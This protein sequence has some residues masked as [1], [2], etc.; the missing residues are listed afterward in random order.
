LEP[1]A[2]SSPPG[3][4]LVEPTVASEPASLKAAPIDSAA[5]GSSALAEV[6][7]LAAAAL[8]A[9]SRRAAPAVG[10]GHVALG[11]A[12]PALLGLLVIVI[13]SAR[14]LRVLAGTVAATSLSL[15]VAALF[16]HALVRR[17]GRGQGAPHPIS[18]RA[19]MLLAG[20]G[21]LSVAI[22]VVL[23]WGLSTVTRGGGEVETAMSLPP[24]PKLTIPD[25]PPEKRADYKLRREGHVLVSGG[26]LV[27]PPS[28]RSDD[29]AFDLLV[30]FH[31]NSQIVQES[32]GAAKIN[33]LVYIVNAGNGFGPYAERY[34]ALSTFDDNL[35]KV[36]E[37]AEKR[38]LKGAKLRRIALSSWSAGYGA[39]ARILD[40]DKNQE[41]VDALLVMDGLHVVSTN[42]RA[43]T[44]VD[45]GRLEPFLRFAQAAAEEKKLF[46]I[47]HAE[48]ANPE[49]PSTHAAADAILGKVGVDRAAASATPPRVSLTTAIGVPKSAE[50][51]LEQTSEARRG[52]LHVRGYK[53]RTPEHQLAHL[54]QMSVTVLPALVERWTP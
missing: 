35:A 33:A 15:A 40:S 39:I 42:E 44:G 9:A 43:A 41:R 24:P 1:T 50:Q 45:P 10:Y 52:G 14:V 6:A 54:V 30:H 32:A 46:S 4:S 3:E 36:Q 18:G 2:V 25:I 27:V 23:T 20:A 19:R 38:G 7:A 5:A 12:A 48:A 34:K 13:A 16:A 31:G 21:A 22:P 28:F 51:R 29:G 53:G 17:Y 47:T 26:L 11:A 37:T 8:Q 49:S